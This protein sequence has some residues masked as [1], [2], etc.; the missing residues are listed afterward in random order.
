MFLLKSKLFF[1]KSYFYS[2]V[3]TVPLKKSLITP[4]KWRR[5]FPPRLFPRFALKR[6]AGDGDGVGLAGEA[7]EPIEGL[8]RDL[9]VTA[10]EDVGVDLVAAGEFDGGGEGGGILEGDEVV[11]SA[12]VEADGEFGEVVSAELGGTGAVFFRDFLRGAAEA[13]GDVCGVG[14]GGGNQGGIP[15]VE[16]GDG[17]PDVYGAEGAWLICCG[18]ERHV[19]A[20]GASEEEDVIDIDSVVAADGVDGVKDVLPGG[21]AAAGEFCD[22]I[23]LEVWSAEFW[24]EE[25]PAVLLTKGEIGILLIEAVETPGMQPDHERDIFAGAGVKKQTGL[26]RTVHAGRNQDLLHNKLLSHQII[27]PI[28]YQ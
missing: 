18:E 9:F 24:E 28:K 4:C 3:G 7:G 25:R 14:V 1:K 2:G 12:V 13:G 11:V 16:V 6:S 27:L 15:G 10:V 5:P 21:G 20:A 17:A 8:G 23:G 26:Q 19:A 22:G